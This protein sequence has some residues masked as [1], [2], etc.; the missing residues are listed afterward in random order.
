MRA[1]GSTSSSGSCSASG[2]YRDKFTGGSPPAPDG[3]STSPPFG[4]PPAH[5]DPARRAVSGIAQR[6][7]QALSRRCL[8]VREQMGGPPSSSSSDVALVR[9]VADRL[10]ALDQ[11]RVVVDGEPRGAAPPEVV[12]TY[13][14]DNE[15][16]LAAP[17]STLVTLASGH[18]S[19]GAADR[20]LEQGSHAAEQRRGVRG[21]RGRGDRAE[22][23]GPAG[24]ASSPWWWSWGGACSPPAGDDEADPTSTTVAPG[25]FTSADL[26]EGVL[27]FDVAGPRAS[28]STGRTPATPAGHRRYRASCAPTCTPVSRVTTA[29]PPGPG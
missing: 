15:A 28:T 1:C 22:A 27:P 10:V 5:R 7:G 4:P 12:E 19:P 29:A 8:R 25:S 3:S 17:T 21:R 9:S 18:G 23:V 14:G 6:G 26:P 2:A 20:S 24:H 11:G 16:A 13:L